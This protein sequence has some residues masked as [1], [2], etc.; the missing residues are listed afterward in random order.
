MLDM[1]GSWKLEEGLVWV[2][3]F[4]GL[5]EKSRFLNERMMETRG[6]NDLCKRKD[7]KLKQQMKVKD[8]RRDSKK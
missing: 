4:G 2:V 8:Q 1:R 7:R 6:C 5:D 3:E